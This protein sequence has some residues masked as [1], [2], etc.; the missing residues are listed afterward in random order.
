MANTLSQKSSQNEN[1]SAFADQVRAERLALLWKLT[2]GV[3]FLLFWALLVVSTSAGL[4]RVGDL[5]VAGV[6]IL[7]GCALTS[8]FLNRNR[9]RVATWCFAGGLYLAFALLLYVESIT[10]QGSATH[11][12]ALALPCVVLAVALLLPLGSALVGLGI[13]IAIA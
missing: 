4:A 3:V 10:M 12:A 1:P 6:V 2:A 13:G 7:I 5:L 11:L 9:Y 8:F